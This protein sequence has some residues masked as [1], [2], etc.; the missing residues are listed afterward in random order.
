MLAVFD[1]HQIL[2]RLQISKGYYAIGCFFG[3]ATTS[4]CFM[5]VNSMLRLFIFGLFSMIY[6]IDVSLCEILKGTHLFSVSNTTLAYFVIVYVVI[7]QYIEK[8]CTYC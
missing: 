7:F 3:N 4:T 2:M 8:I 1:T 6:A 5:P